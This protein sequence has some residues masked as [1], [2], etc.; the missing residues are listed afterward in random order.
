MVRNKVAA[1][2]RHVQLGCIAHGLLQYLSVKFGTQ[3][4]QHFG[5]WLRTMK[6]DRSPSELVVAQALRSSLPHFL[7]TMH[8]RHE[9]EKM[10]VDNADLS[11]LPDLRLSA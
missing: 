10:I 4:W 9:L 5:S 3:V 7:A 1:Y 11:R 2:H 6:T 8:G